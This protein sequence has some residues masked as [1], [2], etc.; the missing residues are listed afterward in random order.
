[1][2]ISEVEYREAADRRRVVLKRLEEGRNRLTEIK[3]LLERFELLQDHYRSDIARLNGI[4]EA[5]SLFA[6]LGEA[7]CPLCGAAPEHH[8][9][10]DDC[11]GNVD[12]IVAAASAEIGKIRL[13]QGELWETITTLRR[14]A[15]SLE[16]R[17][18][19][20]EGSV[21]EVSAQIETI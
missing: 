9:L 2:A 4:E 8:R 10:G 3:S 12:S 18:P 14:E 6:A 13:R 16:R 21:R 20:V 19:V 5:G 1:M 11:D 15:K 7:V 17:L